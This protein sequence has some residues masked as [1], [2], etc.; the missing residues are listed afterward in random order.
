MVLRIRRRAF[1]FVRDGR[2]VRVPASSFVVR[3]RGLPGRGP[4]I[5][6]SL[7][8][9]SLGINFKMSTTARRRRL[10]SL[11]RRIG[12]RRVVGKL[13]AIQVLMKRT[14]PQISSIAAKDAK[15]ISGRFEG[16]R[17]IR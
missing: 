12:E 6:P 17:L 4:K 16:R 3:D 9:G 13:R 11:A 14:A 1:R 10:I 7:K 2:V 5:I 15:F 8:R